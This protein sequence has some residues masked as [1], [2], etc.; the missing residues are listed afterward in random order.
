VLAFPRDVNVE[1][2]LSRC[3]MD[4]DSDMLE[5]EEAGSDSIDP[6]EKRLHSVSILKNMVS[7]IM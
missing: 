2:V 7:A 3:G 5:L 1:V 4:S 6:K